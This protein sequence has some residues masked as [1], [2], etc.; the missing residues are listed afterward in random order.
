MKAY[1]HNTLIIRS[2]KYL[3]KSGLT[4]KSQWLNPFKNKNNN[5]STP[6]KKTHSNIFNYLGIK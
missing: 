5:Q 3:S 6:K 2:S 1:Q 4:K